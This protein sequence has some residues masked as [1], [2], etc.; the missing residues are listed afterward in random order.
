MSFEAATALTAS[1]THR[2]L[3]ASA[4]AAEE[5]PAA[6]TAALG[7][8]GRGIMGGMPGGRSGNDGHGIMG[9]MPGGLRG[10][11]RDFAG[12]PERAAATCACERA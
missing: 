9:G 6:R 12:M 7:G 5:L 3:S 1:L 8:G 11:G 4:A 2:C 10:T